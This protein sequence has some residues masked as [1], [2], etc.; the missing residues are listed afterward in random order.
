[1]CR[2]HAP[3]QA[4]QVALHTGR[5]TL[6]L[7][8]MFVG[9][10]IEPECAGLVTKFIGHRMLYLV[11]LSKSPDALAPARRLSRRC[12]HRPPVAKSRASPAERMGSGATNLSERRMEISIQSLLEGAARANA[13][14]L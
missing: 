5:R 1:L 8:K 6:E 3:R 14:G 13:S 10:A 12:G 7:L 4:L 2:R 9:Q 11:F